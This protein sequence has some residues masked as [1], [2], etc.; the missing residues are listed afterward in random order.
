M[1]G[2]YISTGKDSTHNSVVMFSLPERVGA[3]AR[4]LNVFEVGQQFIICSYTN[5][6]R[7]DEGAKHY[8]EHLNG[9]P[10]TPRHP[11]FEIHGGPV[12][13]PLRWMSNHIVCI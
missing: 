10:K 7:G 2:G 1:G 4:A 5:F 11:Y 8:A 12:P 9:H 6:P 13:P 3:L